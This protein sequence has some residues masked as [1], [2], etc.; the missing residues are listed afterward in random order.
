MSAAHTPGPW[1]YEMHVDGAFEVYSETGNSKGGYLVITDRH[2]HSNFAA[3]NA[4]ARLIAAAPELLNALRTLLAEYN[5]AIDG[6]RTGNYGFDQFEEV[7]AA[8][9]AIKNATGV[10]L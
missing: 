7:V 3:M 6:D 2:Q 9:A 5:G 4:N 10:A 1:G 8:R